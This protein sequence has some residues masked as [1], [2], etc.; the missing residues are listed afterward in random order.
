MKWDRMLQVARGDGV[1]DLLLANARIVNVYTGEVDRGHIAVSGETIVGIGDYKAARTVDLQGKFVAPG[2]ID[3]HVH[4]ES[5]MS[6]VTEFARAVLVHGTT[7]VVADPHEIANVMGSEGIAYMLRAAENQPMNVFFSLPSCVPATDLETAGARLEADDLQGFFSDPRVVALG[8]MMNYPGVVNGDPGVLA[9]LRIA[10]QAAKRIEGHAP[11]L[12]GKALQAYAASGVGS[13]H[14]C[15]SAAEAV[16]KLAAGMRIMIR[17]A[18]GARNLAQ[19]FPVISPKTQRRLMW[20]TD[21]RHAHDLL[22]NGHIDAIIREAVAMGLEPITAIQMA[23]VN[24]AEYFGLHHLGAV[25]PGKQADLVVFSDPEHFVAEAVY[26]RGMLAASRG[27]MRPGLNRPPPEATPSTLRV[28]AA[29]LD[30]TIPAQGSRIRVID[31]VPNQIVTRQ[32]IVD[33]TVSE[34]LTVSDPARDLIKI[35]V[36]ERHTGSGNIG[37]GFVRGMGLKKGALASSVAHDSHNIIVAGV[38]DDDM[39]AAVAAVAAMNGGLAVVSQKETTARL[40]LPIAGLMATDSVA[41]VS[42]RLQEV[43]AAAR[44]CG[45]VPVDPMMT[46]SFLAL[47]VIP[48]LKITDLGLIDVDHFSRVSLFA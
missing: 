16:E 21:D 6:C 48:Q 14:E 37:L 13:D 40:P 26:C 1:A 29:A 39:R 35:A 4:I 46:L 8:E 47:P 34:G 42:R 18:T 3:P 7:S 19:L 17:Q 22:E 25:A 30:F 31:I 27:R 36:V 12:S 9:K 43:L 24:P 38:G 5:A 10:R 2:L 33:A 11:L 32:S 44:A 45:A 28:D 23:T 41:T 15:T 20:C